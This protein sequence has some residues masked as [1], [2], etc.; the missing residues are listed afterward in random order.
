MEGKTNMSKRLAVALLLVPLAC[1]IGGVYGALHNQISY[2]VAPE[3]FTALKFLQFDIPQ[4]MPQR[5]GAALVGWHASWWMGMFIGVPIA[6]LGMGI[7]DVRAQVRSFLLV[8]I[9]VVALTLVLG[10]ISLLLPVAP[11][12]LERA[13]NFPG[14]SDPGA[15][16][17]A[18]MMHSNSYLAGALS[19]PLGL[20]G[21]GLLLWRAR[22]RA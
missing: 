8:A 10:G 14:V 12:S 9:A 1:L 18:G 16:A 15:F 4:S 3:Y 13:Q 11:A 22:R 19:M 7:P 5:L 21:M 20:M 2:T 17:R 6:L